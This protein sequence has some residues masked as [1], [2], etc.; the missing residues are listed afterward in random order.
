MII[1]TINYW[2]CFFTLQNK[3]W[4]N[5][6]ASK[7]VIK[8]W[9]LPLVEVK[10]INGRRR[11]WKSKKRSTGWSWQVRDSIS[12]S[13]GNGVVGGSVKSAPTTITTI[14]NRSTTTSTTS[15]RGGGGCGGDFHR[16][17][18]TVSAAVHVALAVL[19]TS[20]HVPWAPPFL[21]ICPPAPSWLRIHGCS[22][23]VTRLEH[24]P[25]WS[26]FKI[27]HGPT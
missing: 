9:E 27:Q 5:V 10:K 16:L 26:K 25:T 11:A 20:H 24:C 6:I 19:L 2:T 1:C 8:L 17:S 13:N 23:P 4:L 12:I 15:N 14:T 18:W 21:T 22:S 7:H 3:T